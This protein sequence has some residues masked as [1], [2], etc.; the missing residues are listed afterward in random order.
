MKKLFFGN[1]KAV[2]TKPETPPVVAASSA[3]PLHKKPVQTA[4]KLYPPLGVSSADPVNYEDWASSAAVSP[5]APPLNY[6]SYDSGSS[7]ILTQT[8]RSC[9]LG[10]PNHS[11]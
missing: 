6:E 3:S 2:P 10:F 5:S 7:I 1:K 4:Q 8:R 11:T 9:T